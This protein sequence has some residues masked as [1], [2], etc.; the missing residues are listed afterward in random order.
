MGNTLVAV[1]F[2]FDTEPNVLLAA[3][4]TVV[5]TSGSKFAIVKKMADWPMAEQKANLA[6]AVIR[7][8]FAARKA[9]PEK[10]WSSASDAA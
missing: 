10:S 2:P 6:A 1:F 9:A 4:V 8:G 7:G 5:V 3:V